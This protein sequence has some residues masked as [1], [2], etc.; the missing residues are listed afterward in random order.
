MNLEEK[1]DKCIHACRMSMMLHEYHTR[2]V[3][4]V[5]DLS[6]SD[7]ETAILYAE[8]I[9]NNGTYK[10]IFMEPRGSVAELLTKFGLKM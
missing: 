10:G 7:L 1:V 6:Y 3:A 8:T 2:V 9:R 4:G 5:K